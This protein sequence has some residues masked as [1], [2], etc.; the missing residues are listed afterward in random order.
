MDKSLGLVRCCRYWAQSM[1]SLSSTLRPE[2][3]TLTQNGLQDETI[4]QHGAK[5]LLV[6]THTETKRCRWDGNLFTVTSMEARLLFLSCAECYDVAFHFG[7]SFTT[8]VE[9][10]G[11]GSGGDMAVPW[12]VYHR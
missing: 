3:D 1:L 6:N 11:R 4:S 10:F 7:K 5:A 8:I 9:M 2:Y 12:T